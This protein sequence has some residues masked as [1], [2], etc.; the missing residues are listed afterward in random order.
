[1]TGR[2]AVL[3]TTDAVGGVWT[4]A[5]ELARGLADAGTSTRCWD[6]GRRRAT[7]QRGGG[8]GI[9]DG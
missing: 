7:Q 9:S 5:L 6:A 3:M 4:Y 8:R 2:G 1:M